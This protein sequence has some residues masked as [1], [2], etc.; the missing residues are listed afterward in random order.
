MQ[1]VGRRSSIE[2]GSWVIQGNCGSGLRLQPRC[3]W[4]S[5][6][7]ICASVQCIPCGQRAEAPGR[8]SSLRAVFRDMNPCFFLPWSDS[9]SRHDPVLFFRRHSLSRTV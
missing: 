9:I 6:F 4:R 7:S 1:G 2:A 5:A 8:G 3:R